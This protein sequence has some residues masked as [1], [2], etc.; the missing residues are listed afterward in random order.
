MNERPRRVVTCAQELYGVIVN[1]KPHLSTYYEFD[2]WEGN[3]D[4]MIYQRCVGISSYD[5][6]VPIEFCIARS[7]H[8][9]A[10]AVAT[11]E[12]SVSGECVT[13]VCP[14]DKIGVLVN[15]AL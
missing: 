14:S 2:R 6:E 11:R 12:L 13:Y 8:A 3:I 15:V 4:D 10:A 7:A 5:S 9:L 1:F